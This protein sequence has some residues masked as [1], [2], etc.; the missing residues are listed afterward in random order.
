MEQVLPRIIVLPVLSPFVLPAQK[1]SA[2]PR[3]FQ[4]G[5]EERARFEGFTGPAFGRGQDDAY[6]LN[7]LR[8]NVTL[9]PADWLRFAIQVQDSRSAWRR[10][11]APGKVHNPF[12]IREAMVDLGNWDGGWYLRAGR[13]VFAYGDERLLGPGPWSNVPRVFGGARCSSGGLC[14][15][16]SR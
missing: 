14:A 2:L 9:V 5:I 7:R 1:Q 3:W 15:P 12:D 11:P 8:C 4:F 16:V 13:Q 6:L 10:R